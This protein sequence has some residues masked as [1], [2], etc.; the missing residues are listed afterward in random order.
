MLAIQDTAEQLQQELR[1]TEEF[2]ALQAAY[3][4]MKQNELAFALFKNFQEMNFSL[5]QKQMQGQEISEDEIKKAQDLAEKIGNYPEVR[6]LME[7]EQALSHLI[8]ELNK[9]I[10]GPVQGLYAD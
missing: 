10:T 9:T 2:M 5:Q 4:A 8:D 3:G 7:K 6:T 1:Q